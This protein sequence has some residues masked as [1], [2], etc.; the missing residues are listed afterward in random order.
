LSTYLPADAFLIARFQGNPSQLE[1]I[2]PK[3]LGPYVERAVHE[4]GFNLK[5]EVLD[6]LK[7]GLTASLSL[8]PS[9]NLGRGMPELD[10]RR[11][12][13]FGFLHFVAIGEARDETKAAATLAKI[14]AVAE[15]FGARVS[16]EEVRGR[17]VYL[18][19]YS[20]GEGAHF[21]L[22][23]NKAFIAAP[24]VRL[25][26][27]LDALEGKSK[28]G[29]GAPANPALKT[30]LSEGTLSTV[31]D[32]K[33]LANAVRALPSDAWGLG[34][35]AIKTSVVRWFDAMEDLRAITFHASARDGAIQSV[36]TI[37]LE[38]Q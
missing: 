28:T 32:F 21:G 8:A 16:P 17:R 11:T 22:V 1:A 25:E 23:S 35:F 29:T 26:G 18:S 10:V 4:S 7:P 37:R 24:R 33:Q 27:V 14:P 36:V 2:W 13:P 31:L 19:S 38:R 12:N 6:N 15:R 20:Q 5:G 9:A 34:G 30:A 3:L